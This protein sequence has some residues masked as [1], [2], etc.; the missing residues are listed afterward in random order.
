MTVAS[1]PVAKTLPSA[2]KNGCRRRA[3]SPKPRRLAPV[4][5]LTRRRPHVWSGA[6]CGGTA[7]AL[8]P[9]PQGLVRGR[10][11][12][13]RHR[14]HV[15]RLGRTPPICRSRTDRKVVLRGWLHRQRRLAAVSFLVI[16]DSSGLAQ[17][18]VRDAGMAAELASLVEESVL[19]VRGTRGREPPGAGRRRGGRPGRDGARRAGRAAALRPLPPAG[20]CGTADTARP[21]RGRAAA[22]RP[23]GGAADRRRSGRRVPVDAGRAAVSSRSTHPRSSRRRPR[24]A[25]TCS[26]WTTSAGRRTSRRARSSTSRS[27]S[28]RWSACTRWGRCSGPSRTTPRGIL[29][30]TSRSTPSSASSR[31]TAM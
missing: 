26:R 25:R 29:R 23:P 31:T 5:G 19:E 1:G 30:R 15:A 12:L 8:S 18:V 21:R 16:R 13:C 2:G 3:G 22:S 20:D 10:C 14:F 27:W 11:H 9:A 4:I 7:R 6:K 17:V 24:A 28:G